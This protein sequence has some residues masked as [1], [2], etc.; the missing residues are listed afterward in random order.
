MVTLKLYKITLWLQGL[1]TFLTA[2]WPIVHME[3]FMEV[4]GYKTDVWLVKT[5]SILLLA[6]AICMLLSAS[7]RQNIPVVILALI[8]AVGMAYV[9]FYYALND[10]IWNIYMADG[11]IEILFVLSW[12]FILIK[13]TFMQRRKAD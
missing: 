7:S 8:V 5:V 1:Y 12:L 9:D 13:N 4:S 6:I 11:I 2:L 10:T 3:S